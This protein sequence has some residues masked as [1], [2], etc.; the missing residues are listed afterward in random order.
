MNRDTSIFLDAARLFAALTVVAGHVEWSFAPGLMPFIRDYHLAILAVG[1]FF[2]LSGFVIGYVV[3]RNETDARS[4]FLNRAARIY[5]VAIPALFLTFLLDT[6][7]RWLAPDVYHATVNV[8]SV[9]KELAQL[10]I[11]LTFINMAWHLHI[12]PGSNV[13]FWSLAY[14]VPY[15]VVF[16]L[17]YFGG[18]RLRLCAVALMAAAGPYIATLFSLWLLGFGC[19]RLCKRIALTRAQGRALLLFC[20]LC[21]GIAPYLA[22]FFSEDTPFGGGIIG[23][24]QYFVV[25]IP[26]AGTI[27]GFAFADISLARWSGP[28]RW[29]SGATFTIYLVHFPLGALLH[30]LVPNTWPLVGRWFGIFGVLVFVCFLIAECSERRKETW[31]RTLGRVFITGAL[32]SPTNTLRRT[33]RAVIPPWISRT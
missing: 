12:F 31:R 1:I 14:E 17:W 28:I 32:T 15:Y 16:G 3:D 19:Y 9:F 24:G 18:V 11:S 26:F 27:V 4:Y 13:P 25:G 30:V 7:G 10:L 6:C 23:F 21:V 8:W 20:S 5:S 29:A 33:L 22:Q 2:V